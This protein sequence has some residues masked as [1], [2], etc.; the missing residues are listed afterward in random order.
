VSKKVLFLFSSLALV[1][2]VIGIFGM[3]PTVTA[4]QENTERLVTLSVQVTKDTA[5]EAASENAVLMEKVQNALVE[6]GIDEDD[7]STQGYNL[8]QR[9]DYIEGERVSRG[10]QATNT[11]E[12][13]TNDL[14]NVGQYIDVAIEAGANN[15]S[16]IRFTITD[17]EEIKL[18]LLKLAVENATNKA[19]ALVSA[20]GATRG[21]VVTITENSIGGSFYRSPAYEMDGAGDKMMT[22]TPIKAEDLE[23][24]ANITVA[25]AIQ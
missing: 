10:Y 8:Y 22:S 9:Y 18:Q 1:A 23:L 3:Q 5:Q 4:E 14:D 25:F 6:A 7:I 17:Q 16:N 24:T 20:A 12:F 13:K 19:D 15:V 2:L 11:I 21:Q